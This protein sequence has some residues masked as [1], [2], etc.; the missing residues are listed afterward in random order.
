MALDKL[1]EHVGDQAGEPADVYIS[2]DL[3]DP[4]AVA[5]VSGFADRVA[6]LDSGLLAHDDTGAVRVD[7]RA[8][9]ILGGSSAY[10]PAEVAQVLAPADDTGMQAARLDVGLVGSRAQENVEAARDLLEPL[11]ND[12]AADLSALHPGAEAVLTGRPIIRQASLDAISRSLQVS[13]PVAVLLCLLCAWAF[14]RSLRYAVVSLV[15]ILLVIAWLYGFMYAA[16]YSIN[17]VTATIGAISIGVGIDFAIHMTMRFREEIT[18]Q[19]TRLDALRRATAGTGVALVG[20]TISSVVGFAILALAPMPMFASYG[21][22]TA[23][24]ISLALAASLLV[25]PGLLMLVTREPQPHTEAGMRSAS[26]A[27]VAMAA[28]TLPG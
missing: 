22:L 10:T 20:S 6:A 5:A 9:D 14:M 4:A 21:L 28:E 24:M 23:V 13:V 25:L 27:S 12:L 7:R 17:L 8:L 3:D 18:G 2:A 15:P 11:V 19:A 16:G 1:D 26:Q